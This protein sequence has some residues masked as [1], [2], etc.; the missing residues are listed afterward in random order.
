MIT[1]AII[2]VGKRSYGKVMWGT[3][4]FVLEESSPYVVPYVT[5]NVLEMS[6]HCG[7]ANGSMVFLSQA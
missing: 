5:C 2:T 4:P 3:P 6:G 1:F 7:I